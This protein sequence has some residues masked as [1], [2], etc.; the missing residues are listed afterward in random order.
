MSRPRR[1]TL[2]AA[3]AAAAATALPPHLPSADGAR[4]P[5]LEPATPDA[6]ASTILGAMDRTAD[7]CADFYRYAVGGWV[8][9]ATVPA[10]ADFV[11]RTRGALGDAATAWVTAALDSGGTLA[12]EKSGVLYGAC[13]AAAAAGGG[14]PSAAALAPLRPALVLFARN[15]AAAPPVPTVATVA[16]AVAATHRGG[17]AGD[18]LWGW[19]VGS[20]R[21]AGGGGVL[22]HLSPPRHPVDAVSAGAAVPAAAR[23]AFAD[24]MLAAACDAWWVADGGC[25]SAEGRAVHVNA[26]LA[27]EAALD[28]LP[29]ARSAPVPLDSADAPALAAYRSA[30]GPVGP[31]SATRLVDAPF[32]TALSRHV[33]GN[34]TLRAAM[35]AFFVYTA[36][37]RYAARGLLGAAARSAVDVY[38]AAAV[39]TGGD[40]PPPPSSAGRCFAEVAELLPDELSA[41]WAAANVA[42]ADTAAMGGLLDGVRAAA[43]RLVEATPWL[44]APSRAAARR[45]VDG[46]RGHVGVDPGARQPYADVAVAPGAAAYVA[47]LASAA[48][49]AARRRLARVA[50]PPAERRGGRW[51]SPAF[52]LDASYTPWTNT[53]TFNAVLQRWPVLPSAAAAPAPAPAA[54]AYGGAAFVLGHEFGHAFDPVGVRYDAAGVAVPGGWLSPAARAAFTNR[55]ACVTAVYDN[56]TVEQLSVPGAPPVTVNGAAALREALADAFGVAAAADAFAAALAPGGRVADAGGS[57]AATN[58]A[59]A[60]VFTDAQLF[61]VAAVRE[62]VVLLLLVPRVSPCPLSPLLVYAGSPPLPSSKGTP[63]PPPRAHPRGTVVRHRAC[64]QGRAQR[65]A[66]F[67]TLCAH[68][69]HRRPARVSQQGR[70]RAF[71]SSRRHVN[72]P[73]GRL[74]PPVTGGAL[75]T[76]QQH[77]TAAPLRASCRRNGRLHACRWVGASTL[78]AK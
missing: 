59:L 54:L 68:A 55:T 58:P 4:Q 35:P 5:P 75:A 38:T 53:V 22:L 65:H 74:P 66:C 19:S 52:V 67:S 10:G 70:A 46:A 36:T 27:V 13:R 34:T 39:G 17:L 48:A 51:R 71:A 15:A 76:A 77:G 40:V 60:A 31:P 64:Q 30:L 28:G 78:G 2:A 6:V 32:F 23:V 26:A 42:P 45:K 11:D 61:W 12:A 72:P 63:A 50:S 9:A 3:V 43:G 21:Y 29:R 47:G 56:F 37:A 49:A 18:A 16:A 62:R 7:P 44:D 69:R 1:W 57:V 8:D 24:A 33:L 20:D 73:D 25:A 41:A 14:A